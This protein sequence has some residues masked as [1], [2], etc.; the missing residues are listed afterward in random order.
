MLSL[1][2]RF[3]QWLRRR[4]ARRVSLDYARERVRRG[5]AYLDEVDAEWY[6]R[7]DPVTLR[8]S[9]G[10]SCV[11][12]Q[13]HGSFRT[14]LSRARLIDMSSAPRV[15]LSPVAYGFQCVEGVSEVVQD[16]DYAHL[17]TAWREAVRER[18][19]SD[20]ALKHENSTEDRPAVRGERVS[21]PSVAQPV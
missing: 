9:S 12:G 7:V 2:T 3:Q 16:R 6:R 1:T 8:L 10:S 11:L 18:Q 5:A 20:P 4:R 19:A 14:G 13:L 15:S 17:D 21:S